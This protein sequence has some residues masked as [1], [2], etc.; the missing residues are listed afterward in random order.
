MTWRE[1][2]SS[3][4]A[5]SDRLGLL[6]PEPPTGR[7]GNHTR[8]GFAVIISPSRDLTGMPPLNGVTD[9]SRWVCAALTY[10]A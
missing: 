3:G 6:P 5:R 9:L 1:N 4:R 8:D 7:S 10:A 2:E